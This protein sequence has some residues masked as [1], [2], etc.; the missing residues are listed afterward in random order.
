MEIVEF[1]LCSFPSYHITIFASK[2]FLAIGAFVVGLMTAICSIKPLGQSWEHV[3]IV[4]C[5]TN[6]FKIGHLFSLIKID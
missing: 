5:L 3:G 1:C 4:K 2:W 6:H